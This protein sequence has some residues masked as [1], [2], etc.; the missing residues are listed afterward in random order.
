MQPNFTLGD[1]P[2]IPVPADTDNGKGREKEKKKREWG[3]VKEGLPRQFC[4]WE[5]PLLAAEP[6]NSN[7][8][9]WFMEHPKPHLYIP[10][11][12]FC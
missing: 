11:F 7:A 6:Y 9:P 3:E 1:C 12:F 8:L 4:A 5:F 2:P 10:A